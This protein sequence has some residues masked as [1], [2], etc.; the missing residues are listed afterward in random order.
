[1]WNKIYFIAFL[2]TFC[3][4]ICGCATVPPMLE[5]PI[6]KSRTFNAIYEDVWKSL[7]QALTSSGEFISTAEKESGVISFQKIITPPGMIETLA[8][9]NSGVQW[10]NANAAVNI[11][12][13]KVDETHTTVTINSQFWGTGTD[14]GD[15]V[16]GSLLGAMVGAVYYSP[17][18]QYGPL[19]SKG[20]LEKSYLDKT[21][22]LLPTKSY[23]WLEEK[24]VIKSNVSGGV[25]TNIANLNY[26]LLELNGKT[27]AE[28]EKIL[29]KP[30]SIEKWP[31]GKIMN[32]HYQIND[33]II[34]V[35]YSKR[36][37]RATGYSY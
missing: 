9:C 23:A 2:I 6:E 17:L 7:V 24:K 20:V 26:K 30:F 8:L 36:N 28:V 22:N 25:R 12:A 34:T 31:N 32:V 27:P 15:Q 10:N 21:A 5:R 37:E 16:M 1:M 19:S 33:K 3:F 29:G 13:V 18:R 35:S 4:L 14:T 11:T